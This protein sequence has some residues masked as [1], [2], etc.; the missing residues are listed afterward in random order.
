MLTFMVPFL[1]MS[2]AAGSVVDVKGTSDGNLPTLPWSS[3]LCCSSPPDHL[4]QQ[5][6]GE[7]NGG[8]VVSLEEPSDQGQTHAPKC[9]FMKSTNTQG[10]SHGSSRAACWDIQCRLDKAGERLICDSKQRVTS[11]ART[12][13][14]VSLHCLLTQPDREIYTTHGTDLEEDST[15]CSFA[16]HSLSG[17]VVVTANVSSVPAGTSVS[18]SVRLRLDVTY[19]PERVLASVGEEVTLYC[20]LEGRRGNAST[21]KWLKNEKEDSDIQYTAVNNHV[22]KITVGPSEQRLYDILRCCQSSGNEPSCNSRYATILIK[23][24]VIDITCVTKGNLDDMTCSWKVFEI[25][26]NVRSILTEQT[27]EE[28][29]ESERLGSLSVDN[30]HTC[31][32]RGELTS[33]TFQPIRVAA[34]YKLWMEAQTDNSTRSRPVYLRPMDHVK[35]EPPSELS[36]ESL[37]SGALKLVWKPPAQQ[38]PFD[39]QYQVRY[40]LFNDIA[41]NPWKVLASQ[42]ELWADVPDPKVCAVYKVEVR[43]T[44][45]KT[46]DLWS[47]WSSTFNTMS[48]NSRAPEQGPD[49]WRVFPARAQTNVTLLFKDSTITKPTYCVEGLVVQHQD[50]GGTVTEEDIGLVSTY[51]FEWKNEVHFVTVKANN[52]RGVSSSNTNMTLMKQP[53]SQCMRSFSASRVNSSCVV[54]SWSLQPGGRIPSSLVV[55]CSVQNSVVRESWT[56]LPPEQL[57]YL[58]GNFYGS[59][60]YLFVLYPVFVDGEGEPMRAKVFREDDSGFIVLMMSIFFLSIVLF[61]ALVAFQNHLKTFLWKDVPNP[62]N[63]SWA[64][65]MD[66]RKADTMEKLFRYPEGLPAWPL[67]LVSETICQATIMEKTEP[68]SPDKESFRIPDFASSPLQEDKLP[69]LPE[70]CRLSDILAQLPVIYTTVVLPDAFHHPLVASLSP[71]SDK[72]NKYASNY[73]ISDSFPGGPWELE[74]LLAGESN[75]D[76]QISLSYHTVEPPSRTSSAAQQEARGVVKGA[77]R[78]GGRFQAA[79]LP[80][81]EVGPLYRSV[82]VRSRLLWSRGRNNPLNMRK[83][84]SVLTVSPNDDIKEPLDTGVSEYTCTLGVDLRRGRRRFSGNLQLPPLSWRQAERSRTPDDDWV[85]RP[86]F[87]PICPPPRIDITP[88]EP[89]CV[90]RTSQLG[91]NAPLKVSQTSWTRPHV[92][93]ARGVCLQFLPP[94]LL[95]HQSSATPPMSQP[96]FILRRDRG[97]LAVPKPT[98]IDPALDA[99]GN[100]TPI[101]L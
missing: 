91:P 24:P 35:P 5:G 27:C 54:L 63:C 90:R 33:C 58:H 7:N 3:E 94:P 77:G 21:T 22:S 15:R 18:L 75:M 53:I 65:G 72:G 32:P 1:L 87:L 60:E 29:K 96:P 51:S 17:I 68:T 74:N 66:F 37:S 61:V 26:K 10:P 13:L 47:D 82:C 88:V 67:L 62:N 19:L 9:S 31:Q 55:V 101:R 80:V 23:D 71:S 64:Q 14:A 45:V 34:C 52:S 36:A 76:P 99:G 95:L 39:M 11:A 40:A 56:R 25:Q 57:L 42:S 43:C 50:S 46:P 69:K 83:S 20:G 97:V 85:V 38:M 92:E 100:M 2:Q 98:P 84:R 44:Y 79:C 6:D 59:E 4:N 70:H 89:E 73:D 41:K 30:Q 86:T 49:F 93:T 78:D 8:S 28:M 81:T 48:H 16:L 12:A